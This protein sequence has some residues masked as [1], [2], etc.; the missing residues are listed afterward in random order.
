VAG[1]SKDS[2]ESLTESMEHNAPWELGSCTAV[3]EIT[4]VLRNLKIYCSV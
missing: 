3:Q 2:S 4:H 1:F